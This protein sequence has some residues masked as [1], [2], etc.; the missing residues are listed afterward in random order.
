MIEALV[1]LAVRRRGWVLAGWALVA[2]GLFALA[3][4][5]KLDALP[6]ISDPQVVIYAKWPRSPELLDT[7]VVDPLVRALAGS[8]GVEDRKS[9]RLNSSHT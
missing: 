3:L 8:P 2:A 5:L 7:E 6:D 1:A 9:T 4:R